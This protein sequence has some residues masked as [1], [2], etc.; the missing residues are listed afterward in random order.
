MT[1]VLRYGDT[2]YDVIEVDVTRSIGA[3]NLAKVKCIV[4]IPIES[5]VWLQ[6][7]GNYVMR[8]YVKKKTVEDEVVYKYEIT[9]AMGEMSDQ[10]VYE[11]LKVY[12]VEGQTIHSIVTDLLTGTGWS[13]G[14]MGN[15]AY[16]DWETDRK[17]TRLNSSHITRSRMPSSA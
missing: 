12:D 15:V 13:L 16:R 10:I 2:S 6:K 17:S 14:V 5:E 11:G 3:L 8:G 4:D 9:E 1:W 7:N